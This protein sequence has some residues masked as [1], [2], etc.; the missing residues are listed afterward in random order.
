MRLL[1][2]ASGDAEYARTRSDKDAVVSRFDAQD[3]LLWTWVGRHHTDVF[4]L[5]REDLDQHYR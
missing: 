3:L 4:M 5:T 1:V 2:K